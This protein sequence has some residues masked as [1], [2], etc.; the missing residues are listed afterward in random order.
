VVSEGEVEPAKKG[1]PWRVQE[2]DWTGAAAASAYAPAGAAQKPIDPSSLAFLEAARGRL[3]AARE[4]AAQAAGF[5]PNDSLGQPFEDASAGFAAT[6]D[7]VLDDA[8]RLLDEMQGGNDPALAAVA[9]GHS[10]DMLTRGFFDHRT[11]EGLVPA[12]RIAR[13]G[14]RFTLTGE[15]LYLVEGGIPAAAALASSIVS[16]W[17]NTKDHRRNILDPAFRYLGVGVAASTRVVIATQLFGG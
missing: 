14:L 8:L 2:P 13:Q 12:D 3:D 6:Q 4:A 5:A 17:M 7:F 11:P 1:Q 10:Q 15:N 9:R 16:G